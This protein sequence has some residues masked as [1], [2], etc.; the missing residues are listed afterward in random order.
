MGMHSLTADLEVA[1]QRQQEE[2]QRGGGA[3]LGRT[4]SRGSGLNGAE[5]SYA[6]SP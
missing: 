3:G 4:S 1:H 5:V 2:Q 6:R